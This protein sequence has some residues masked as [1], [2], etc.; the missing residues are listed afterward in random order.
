MSPRLSLAPPSGFLGWFS[1]ALLRPQPEPGIQEGRIFTSEIIV[2]RTRQGLVKRALALTWVNALGE[3]TW[4]L[5]QVIQ[6]GQPGTKQRAHA[7]EVVRA[8][9][10]AGGYKAADPL[11]ITAEN[12]K[13]LRVGLVLVEGK[14]WHKPD[15]K[16]IQV[17]RF[18]C[19]L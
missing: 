10:W 2:S 16:I 4:Y 17:S 19:H 11:V 9:L 1:N 7:I 6:L 13:G 5:P 18:M 8:I 12:M 3:I 15:L 14:H